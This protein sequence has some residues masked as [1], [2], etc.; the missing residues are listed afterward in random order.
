MRDTTAAVDVAAREEVVIADL[1]GS[2][3]AAGFPAVFHEVDRVQ[4]VLQ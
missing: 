3:Q 4:G 1:P 2:G